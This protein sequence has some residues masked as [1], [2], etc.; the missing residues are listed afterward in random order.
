MPEKE[1][2]DLDY[3]YLHITLPSGE[4]LTLTLD[5]AKHD[6]DTLYTW[7]QY[8]TV[9]RAGYDVVDPDPFEAEIAAADEAEE[10]VF[11]D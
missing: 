9:A 8:H 1:S 7:S 5:G 10:E 2:I 4:T 11:G 6:H 3:S